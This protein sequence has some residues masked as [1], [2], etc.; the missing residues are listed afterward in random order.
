MQSEEDRLHMRSGKGAWRQFHR[1]HATTRCGR[2]VRNR[3][4]GRTMF[5]IPLILVLASAGCTSGGA[6]SGSSTNGVGAG[7]GSTVTPPPSPA[8][9]GGLIVLRRNPD[10]SAFTIYTVRPD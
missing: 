8:G 6:S 4:L 1:P 10:D 5:G 3:M 7:T 2:S 9:P